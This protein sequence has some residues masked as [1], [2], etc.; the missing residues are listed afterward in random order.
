MGGRRLGPGDCIEALGEGIH[1]IRELLDA[2]A[3]G[4]VQFEG[5]HHRLAGAL[6]G[7]APVHDISL[8]VGR[9]GP[10]C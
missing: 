1:V 5:K 6:R 7:P 4:G 3:Q 9:S 2:R 8:W 10:G